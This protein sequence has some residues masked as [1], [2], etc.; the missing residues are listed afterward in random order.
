MEQPEPMLGSPMLCYCSQAQLR[1]IT[2]STAAVTQQ[3]YLQISL[4]IIAGI[5]MLFGI[6]NM[7]DIGGL[8]VFIFGWSICSFNLF[9]GLFMDVL[10]TLSD[11]NGMSESDYNANY[12]TN[13]T[14]SVTWVICNIS[15]YSTIMCTG[16]LLLVLFLQ[17]KSQVNLLY[18]IIITDVVLLSIP[19][20]LL[21]VLVICWWGRFLLSC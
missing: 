18:G 21:L 1:A 4:G 10:S 17:T 5:N 20:V 9:H 15:V 6:L 3:G 16:Y 13:F 7:N 8:Y 11:P 12:H 14:M 2:M 19:Y